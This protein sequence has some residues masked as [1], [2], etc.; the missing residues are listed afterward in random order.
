LVT[1][2]SPMLAAWT[3]VGYKTDPE[4]TLGNI[5]LY[6]GIKPVTLSGHVSAKIPTSVDMS[7]NV[8]YTN[9]KLTVQDQ[10]VGYARISYINNLSR[11]SQFKFSAM[12]TTTGE[13]RV[14]NELKLQF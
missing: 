5:G 14:V 11:H 2:V 8:V 1:E 3:E 12:G 4:S 10:T 7:G 13:Y 9:K 6:A